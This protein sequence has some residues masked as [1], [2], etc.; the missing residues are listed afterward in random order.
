MRETICYVF[1]KIDKADCQG[2]EP[3]R[4]WASLN[5]S[6]DDWFSLRFLCVPKA[7]CLVKAMV[8]PIVMYRCESCIIK[9][10]ECQRIDAF[11]LWYKR[12]LLRIPWTSRRWNQSVLKKINP[13]YSLE[14]TVA[15]PEAPVLWPPDTKSWL[16]RKDPN[17]GKDWWQKEK[18]A[19]EDE[20]VR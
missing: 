3:H 20:M 2:F 11:E 12:R 4:S 16:I 5:N 19:A 7:V 13:E 10:A 8:F 6:E 9:K 15:E 18:G 17:A 14:R 1:H